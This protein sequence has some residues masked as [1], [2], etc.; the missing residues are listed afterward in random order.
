[1]TI[2]KLKD[3]ANEM[4]KYIRSKKSKRSKRSKR[5]QKKNPNRNNPLVQRKLQVLQLLIRLKKFQQQK[6]QL[7]VQFALT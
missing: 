6:I 7:K 3:V 5:S 1:M 4:K 2:K